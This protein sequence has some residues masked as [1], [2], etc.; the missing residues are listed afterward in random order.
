MLPPPEIAANEPAETRNQSLAKP[1]IPP[2]P[3]SP[4]VLLPEPIYQPGP[5]ISPALRQSFASIK[6]EIHIGVD[7]DENGN[8]TRAHLIDGLEDSPS[9]LVN[10]ASSAARLWR[11]RPAKIGEKPVRSTMVLV[12]KFSL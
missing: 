4:P 11:F 3:K 2:P 1:P 9:L 7:I 10:A 6:K 5:S 8:V 12:F